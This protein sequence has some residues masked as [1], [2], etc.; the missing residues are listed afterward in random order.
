MAD[1]RWWRQGSPYGDVTVLVSDV[2]V[3][4]IS[5]PADAVDAAEEVEGAR[6]E[7]DEVVAGQLAEWFAGTRHAF[8]LPLDLDGVD[9][10]RRTVLETLIREVP[11]GE[12][13]SYGELAELAGKPRAARA[14]GSAMAS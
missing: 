4:S 9:G 6:Q 2:G 14:V 7:R 5:L 1:L 13:V 11:W 10:F 8:D 12:A 3:R